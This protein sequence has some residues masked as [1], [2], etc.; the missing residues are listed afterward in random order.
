[1]MKYLIDRLAYI[2]HRQEFFNKCALILATTNMTN[3]RRTIHTMGAATYSWGFNTIGTKGFK[4]LSSNDSKET[5][6][7]K[8]Q[9]DIRKLARKLCIGI[10]ENSYLN[11]SFISLAAFKIQQKYRG[12]PELSS[13]TDYNYWKKHG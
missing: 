12:N 1:M 11:P 10:K 4:N 5:L 13:P 3:L 8:H 9:K 2:C 6:K 7:Q